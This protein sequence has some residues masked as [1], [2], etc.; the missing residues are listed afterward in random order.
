M[1]NNDGL[2]NYRDKKIIFIGNRT[3]GKC[4]GER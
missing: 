3:Q 2:K 1:T 4:V